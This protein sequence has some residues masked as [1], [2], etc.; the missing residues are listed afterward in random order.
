MLMSVR[1]ARMKRSKNTNAV[2]TA[3]SARPIGIMVATNVLNTIMRTMSAA[4]SERLL[5]P[6]VRW[7]ELRVAVELDLH[8]GRLDRLADGIFDGDDLLAIFGLD[9]LVELRLGV[10]G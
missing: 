8:A 9:R 5:G 2:P 7:R 6:P 3:A 10:R 1:P 4:N